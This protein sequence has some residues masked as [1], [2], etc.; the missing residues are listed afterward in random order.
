VAQIVHA[1]NGKISVSSKPDQG[2][3]F[4]VTLPILEED[5]G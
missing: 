4:T 1:H 5:E 3:K 2:A